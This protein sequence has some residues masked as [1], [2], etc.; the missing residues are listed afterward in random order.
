MTRSWKVYV[1]PFPSKRLSPHGESKHHP[2][3]ERKITALP[4]LAPSSP[5][6][7]DVFWLLHK[8]RKNWLLYSMTVPLA[9]G[10]EQIFSWSFISHSR[11]GHTVTSFH[12]EV[13]R[14][15][16][17]FLSPG[18]VEMILTHTLWQHLSPSPIPSHREGHFSTS[19]TGRFPWELAAQRESE[20]Q[21]GKREQKDG[22]P[23]FQ[24]S[25]LRQSTPLY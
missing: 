25:E 2:K 11:K 22:M 21:R 4:L 16:S 20:R 17:G 23:Q 6:C 9:E 13:K 1:I 14:E 19:R 7:W 5:A 3:C 24:S 12:S 15:S 10:Q 18:S 8:E